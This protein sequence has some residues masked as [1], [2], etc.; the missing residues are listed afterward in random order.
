MGVQT[1]IDRIAN[2][3]ED[4]SAAIEAK[5]VSV[6]SGTSLDGMAELIESISAGG[7]LSN[8]TVD[9]ESSGSDF[10]FDVACVE[11]NPDGELVS[12]HYIFTGAAPIYCAVG[13]VLSV[14][15]DMWPYQILGSDN[16]TDLCVTANGYTATF[17]VPSTMATITFY[18]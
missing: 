14:S 18:D 8:T 7:G 6:P 17:T 13:S 3:K 16:I 15:T 9:I 10:T 11:V 12:E 5:G 1:Q 2:A 4:I